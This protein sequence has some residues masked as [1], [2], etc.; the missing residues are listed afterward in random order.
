MP[1]VQ[2]AEDGVLWGVEPAGRDVQAPDKRLDPP[3]PR[4]VAGGVAQ[5]ALLVVREHRLG[6][7]KPDHPGHRGDVPEGLAA[8]AVPHHQLADDFAVPEEGPGLFVVR[9]DDARLGHPHQLV[10]RL[11]VDGHELV[12][13][14]DQH[15]N[16]EEG[17]GAFEMAGGAPKEKIAKCEK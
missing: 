9:A 3:L 10:E 4:D 17:C 8:P 15:R 13:D 11:V 2:R 1:R 14:G 5:D 16:P 12:P 7:E 6:P